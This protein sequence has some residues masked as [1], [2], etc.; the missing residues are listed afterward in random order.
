M[1]RIFNRVLLYTKAILLC[2]CVCV[3]VCVFSHSVMSD[4]TWPHGLYLPKLLYPWNFSRQENWS[5]SPFPT[6]RNLS[7]SGQYK[8]SQRVKG[9]EG[10]SDSSRIASLT[11]CFSV[12]TSSK[13]FTKQP[14]WYSKLLELVKGILKLLTFLVFVNCILVLFTGSFSK[15]KESLPLWGSSQFFKNTQIISKTC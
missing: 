10:F 2:V 5:G 14:E 3:C 15:R 11:Y 7:D 1:L 4:S 9:M 6:P 12:C 8:F 13:L